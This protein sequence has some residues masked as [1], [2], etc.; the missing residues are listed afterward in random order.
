MNW[1]EECGYDYN[2]FTIKP[3]EEFDLFFDGKNVVGDVINNLAEGES[4]ILKGPLGTGKT[5][6][7]KS[8]KDEFGGDRKL[9]YYNAFSASSPI[10]YER[11]LEKAGNVFSR[12]FRYKSR[13]V[14]LFID[15]AQ[16]LDKEVL[17]ELSSF[18]DGH[19][20]SVVLAS[21]DVNFKVPSALKDYFSVEI[22]LGNFTLD[23]AMNI[24]VDRLGDDYENVI[25]DNEIEDIH[26]RVKTPR[27]FLL[28]CEEFAKD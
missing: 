5:S 18:M 4:I 1:Y 13:D 21:S 9:Y 22:N 3:V 26:K 27:E 10:N 2:P 11:V 24:I 15:E 14:I 17:E 7:L 12:V 20:R 25:S 19:F 16:H 23:D 28:A 6:I 8:I